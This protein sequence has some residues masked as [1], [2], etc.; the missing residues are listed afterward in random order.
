MIF[1]K[2][3][4]THFNFTFDNMVLETV[5]SFKYLGIY[6]FKNGCWN[7]TQQHISKHSLYSLHNLFIV[8]KQLNLSTLESCKLFD[9]LLSPILNYGAEIFGYHPAKEIETVHCKFLR[10][11]LGDRKSTNLVALYGELG[12]HPM[13]IERKIRMIKYWIKLLR[14]RD[15]SLLKSSI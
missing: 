4:K 1:E 11:I 6:L 14:S 5:D 10:K 13:I 8:F 7:R 9:S 12:R 2:G 3:R 15:N